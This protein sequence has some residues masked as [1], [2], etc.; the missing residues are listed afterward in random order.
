MLRSGSIRADLP[1]G[2][3]IIKFLDIYKYSDLENVATG[4]DSSY[5][6]LS[7]FYHDE[8]LANSFR[9]F[10]SRSGFKLKPN[11][12]IRFEVHRANCPKNSEFVKFPVDPHVDDN[13]EMNP[14]TCLFYR[15]VFTGG[16]LEVYTVR[17]NLYTFDL[18][19][20][21]KNSLKYVILRGD[22]LHHVHNLYEGHR[23]VFAV[24]AEREN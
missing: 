2:E 11:G 23:E 18:S 3:H 6:R 21:D 14:I 15:G 13:E 4:E 9:E 7:A 12:K 5:W 16:E 22:L 19:N 8:H 10:I 20:G 17:P 1:I 24:R